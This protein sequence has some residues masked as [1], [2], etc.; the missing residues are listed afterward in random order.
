M[1]ISRYELDKLGTDKIVDQW[2]WLSA[3]DGITAFKNE[4]NR[5]AQEMEFDVKFNDPSDEE[6]ISVDY[7]E[8]SED[9]YIIF[10]IR[11]A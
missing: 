5:A 8:L 4:W 6:L 10:L 2:Q 1:K 7:I 3:I 11:I 9:Q